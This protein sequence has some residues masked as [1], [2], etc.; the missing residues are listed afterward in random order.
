M[1]FHRHRRQPRHL[2]R[3]HHNHYQIML[4]NVLDACVGALG[5]WAVGYGIAYGNKTGSSQVSLVGD[6]VRRANQYAAFEERIDATLRSI[7]HHQASIAPL[8]IEAAPTFE[9][10]CLATRSLAHPSA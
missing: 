2:L 3:R 7:E 4:K 5:F 9:V 6:E 1:N 8:D 10:S